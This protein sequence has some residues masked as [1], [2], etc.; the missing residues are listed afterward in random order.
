MHQESFP[1]CFRETKTMLLFN[2]LEL[3]ET[4]IA[5]NICPG[6]PNKKK[7]KT[8]LKIKKMK[9]MECECEL[10]DDQEDHISFSNLK[11]TMTN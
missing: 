3:Q 4:T 1:L 7:D 8:N 11:F 6:T 10:S 2:F 5:A 9:K